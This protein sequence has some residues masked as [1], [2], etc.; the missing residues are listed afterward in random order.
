MFY[1]FLALK[2]LVGLCFGSSHCTYS[3]V[4]HGSLFLWRSNLLDFVKQSWNRGSLFCLGLQRLLSPRLSDSL[5]ETWVLKRIWLTFPIL[6]PECFM[7]NQRVQICPFIQLWSR[8]DIFGKLRLELILP[9]QRSKFFLWQEVKKPFSFL[10]QVSSVKLIPKAGP[11]GLPALRRN[12]NEVGRNSHKYFSF[13]WNSDLMCT[14]YF[15]MNSF[16]LFLSPHLSF[17]WFILSN[18]SLKNCTNFTICPVCNAT[19]FIVFPIP[20]KTLTFT[21]TWN[22]PKL[23]NI[24][25]YNF[26]PFNWSVLLLLLLLL[27]L[28]PSLE[29]LELSRPVYKIW[30]NGLILELMVS[31]QQTWRVWWNGIICKWY[32]I[33]TG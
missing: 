23:A 29:L 3:Q 5:V 2:P 24:H 19:I 12:E 31:K 7:A 15:N 28:L 22:S 10:W 32:H 11:K 16:P 26:M 9:E 21:I 17:P 20:I 1:T 8:L 4:S 18:I 33:P 6:A 14:E 13:Y 25:Q 30:K 27:L